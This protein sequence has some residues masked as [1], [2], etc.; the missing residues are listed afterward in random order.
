MNIDSELYIKRLGLRIK[1]LRMAKGL[2]Q[3]EL[4]LRMY[5]DKP[6][7]RKIEKGKNITVN[8]SLRVCEAL[9]ITMSYLFDF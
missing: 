6:N 1:E 7:L 8:T 5:M 3:N 4:A 2:S 9:N